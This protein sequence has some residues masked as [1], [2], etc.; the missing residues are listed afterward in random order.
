MKGAAGGRGKWR[1]GK[2][3]SFARVCPSQS[4]PR[5]EA[6][7]CKGRGASSVT[8]SEGAEASPVRKK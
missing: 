3:F 2:H 4:Q 1:L 7:A 8:T 5:G 6:Q